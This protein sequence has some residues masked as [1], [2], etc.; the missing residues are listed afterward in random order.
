[1][2]GSKADQYRDAYFA[3][4][5]REAT[6]AQVEQGV[7]KITVLSAINIDPVMLSEIQ[8]SDVARS[9]AELYDA[10]PTQVAEVMAEAI[11]DLQA[12]IP[13]HSDIAQQAEIVEW[14][15][16]SEQFVQRNVVPLLVAAVLVSVLALGM[17]G[18]VTA[19]FAYDAGFAAQTH[20]A[21]CKMVADIFDA[22]NRD[23]VGPVK[24]FIGSEYNARC[25]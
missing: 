1:M 11:A 8:T 14:L 2:S 6:I 23:R 12:S 7:S 17:V 13:A 15:R 18:G 25:R 5:R 20:R 10:L 16:A 21:G 9:N 22:A 19:R 4:N 24:R 3:W